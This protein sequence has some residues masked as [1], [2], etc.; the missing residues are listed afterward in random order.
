MHELS[1]A[2][3]VVSTV[4]EALPVPAPR[5]LQVRLR[6]GELSGIVPQ[7]L[8][9]AYDVATQGTPLADA[10]LVIERSPIVVSCPTCGDQPIPSAH[11]FRCPVC[12]VPCGNVVGGKELEILDITL[13]DA[14]L[15]S[16][17]VGA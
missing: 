4:V 15:A 8:E 16:D 12:S 9:F 17:L 13:D 10:V 11:D 2:H 7:A 14:A 6:I 5:V 1:V 3:A